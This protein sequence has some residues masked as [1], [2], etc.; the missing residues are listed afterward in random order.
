MGTT[1]QILQAP[2]IEGSDGDFYG[3]TRGGSTSSDYGSVYKIT[4]SG[5]FTTLH[6]FAVSDGAGPI[7]PL[8]EGTDG[9]FY[10]T[11]QFG[12]THGVGTIFR[13]SSSGNFATLFNAD[14]T[15]GRW[16]FE[17]IQ[18][19]DGNFYG[20]A[21]YGGSAGGGVV[22]KMTP[23]GRLTV[24]HNFTGGSDGSNQTGLMQA[25]DGN[26]YGL[27]NLGGAAGWGVLFRITPTG[28]FTVLHNFDW[29][30]GASPQATLLQHTNGVLYSTTTVGGT[31]NGGDGTFYSFDVGLG[32]FVRF[33]PEARAIEHTVEVLGQGFTGTSAVSFN[34]AA[35]A[36]KVVSDTFL[37]A[38][39]P[40]GA[41]S[42]FVTVTTPSGT[43]KSNKKFRATPQI[44]SFSPTSGPVGTSVVITG[45]S[46]R[47]ASVLT[48]ARQWKMSFTVDSDT[49]I[50]AIVP[51]AATG[52]V[53]GTIAVR[54]P[55][56]RVE[57]TGRFTVT[58]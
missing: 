45:K 15:H 1:A 56:G 13:I 26:F 33:L 41:T 7:G 39:V 28:T 27:N 43:L 9:Y 10:G 54:T 19:T 51:A 23:G 32:P 11:T 8:V 55:G 25:T 20:V 52:G 50:T 57:S 40:S 6:R 21:S 12:G 38:T 31:G 24:L 34:G 35:A 14:D 48:F 22:F 5:T 46:L 44:L 3:S 30:S 16:P 37:T 29:G 49:Q 2:P 58:D 42:G 18:G 53:S 47:Q 4:P 36:F 17:P